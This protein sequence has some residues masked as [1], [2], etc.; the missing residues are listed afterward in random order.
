ML[1]KGHVINTSSF[2]KKHFQQ[3]TGPG[4]DSCGKKL[5]Q[6]ISGDTNK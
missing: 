5:G 6:W 3:G 4:L 2:K 1:N